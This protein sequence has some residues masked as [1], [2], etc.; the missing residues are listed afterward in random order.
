MFLIP[1]KDSTAYLNIH[2]LLLILIQ[3]PKETPRPTSSCSAR[4]M[5]ICSRDGTETEHLQQVPDLPWDLL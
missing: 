1:P 4:K 2:H 3:V 5:L